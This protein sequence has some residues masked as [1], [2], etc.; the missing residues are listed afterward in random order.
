MHAHI[1][2]PTEYI[3]HHLH[4]LTLNLHNFT[5]SDGGFW[6]LN[7]DTLAISFLLGS[8]FLFLFHKAAKY[9]VSDVPEHLQ[10]FVEIMISFANGQVKDTFHSANLFIGSLALTIFMWVFLMNFMDLIPVDL[11]PIGLSDIGVPYS[12]VVATAD[13]NLTFA[14]SISVFFILLFLGIRAKGFRHYLQDM[15]FAPFGK[16]LL[17]VNVI[18]HLVEEFARIV[19]LSLRLFGNLYAGELI[20]ILIALLPWWC[21]WS[22]GLPW[23]LFHILIIVL[24]AFIFMMLTI[25]YI[26]LAHESH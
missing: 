22:L 17:P 7:L 5:I 4:H 21:Q 25:V 26:S 19:S 6:T 15:S 10:N 8:V 1:V 18:M 23:T 12:R 11:I 14:L 3:T 16:F 2:T 24:Q 13:L 20:F 9:A